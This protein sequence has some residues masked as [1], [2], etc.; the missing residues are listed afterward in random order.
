M[1]PVIPQPK[2]VKKGNGSVSPGKIAR[3]DGFEAVNAFEDYRRR[4]SLPEGETPIECR[5]D[6]NLASGAYTLSCASSV[7]LSASDESGMNHAF[8]ALL[9]LCVSTSEEGFEAVSVE[10]AASYPYRGLMIDTARIF[11]PLDNLLSYIDL[12]WLFRFSHL[13]IHFSDDQSFTL[14]SRAFP[15][16]PTEGRHYSEEE[17]EKLVNYAGS[18]GIKIMP[19]IDLPGHC[20]SFSEAYPE[21]FTSG[22]TKHIIAFT[23]RSFEAFETLFAEIAGMF[24]DSD[25]IHIGGDEADIAAWLRDEESRAYAAECGIPVDGDERLSA[26]RILATFVKKLS[27]IVLSLGKTPVCWEGFSREVNCLVPKTTEVFSWELFYQTTSD[28]M[29][30]GYKIINGSWIPNYIVWPNHMRPVE[31]LF[32]WSPK[33][34]QAIHAGSAFKDEPYFLPDYDRLIGGQLLSWGDHGVNTDDPEGHLRGEFAAIAER[35]PATAEGLWN[36]EKNV[37]FE[38]FEKTRFALA[39]VVGSLC[40]R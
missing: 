12:C 10:D 5:R 18:R 13:H 35:A 34:F 33:R 4:F 38:Q 31:E 32:N 15:L 6:E 30:G 3:N 26:E 11:H 40:E 16:L 29:S 25:R 20:R 37:S 19:E 22:E 36:A 1:I 39:P 21:I 23:A 27:E 17:I 7:V 14:P 2:K 28:L 24:P 8:A 9:Q